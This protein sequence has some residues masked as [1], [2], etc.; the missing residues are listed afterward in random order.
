MNA[1]DFS[2]R[3][4]LHR[5]DGTALSAKHMQQMHKKIFG[6]EYMGDKGY[7][8]RDRLAR[9]TD[10]ELNNAHCELIEFYKSR[11]HG[12]PFKRGRSIGAKNKDSNTET[13]PFDGI[14][15]ETENMLCEGLDSLTQTPAQLPAPTGD[16]S[17]YAL[18]G[19]CENNFEKVFE[20][21][22]THS[23]AI[24]KILDR[25]DNIK[26]NTPT[27]VE[28]KRN[29]LPPIEMGIQHRNFPLLLKMC[30]AAMRSGSHLN[31]WI[32]GP[33]G[34]GKTSAA[35]NVCKALFGS[36][37]KY[38]YN[39]ALA[40][41]FQVT[42]FMDANGKYVSTPFRQAWEHGGVYLF[43][44]IDGSMP[45]ALLALNGALANGVASFPD[46]MVP[47]HKDCIII[48][49]ANTTGLGGTTE[50]VGRFK[51]DAALTDRFVY[52]DWPHDMALED[53]LCANKD[54]L[55][56]VRNVRDNCQ[57]IKYKGQIPSM[58]ASI[59]GEALLAA[60]IELEYVIDATIRKGVSE[61]D[62]NNIKPR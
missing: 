60:G 7:E 32:Y 61:A 16:L 62:W 8:L 57:R 58:R 21:A 25:L 5:T 9:A 24:N 15:A 37:D 26:L 43:D 36:L 19:Y 6:S 55:K 46:K 3:E 44:E 10:A 39:G 30:S 38:H 48:A 35:E 29:E 51:Q 18:K 33:K 53:Y 27:I 45:D 1:R 12:R 52:L 22:N 41:S 13:N 50:Y 40:T 14:I 17:I 28:I 49:G 34:S 31:V 23:D 54:W 4:R 42:G 2:I 20:G 47:R 56:I 11:G 59:Y